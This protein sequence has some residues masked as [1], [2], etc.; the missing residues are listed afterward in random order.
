MALF[1]VAPM[2]LSDES[3]G[4]NGLANFKKLIGCSLLLASLFG[5]AQPIETAVA[6]TAASIKKTP[7]PK[8]EFKDFL[9]AY[10]ED[11]RVQQAFT[12]FPLRKQRLDLM[13]EPEPK[14]V[15]ESLR[16][17][18]VKYPIFP[19]TAER[20]SKSLNLRIDRLDASHVKVS[21]TKPDTDYQ[22]VY[23][24]SKAGCWRL[25]AIEDWSL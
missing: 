13:A 23:R 8:G 3:I 1:S 11:I 6:D 4:R 20:R 5:Q 22:V 18:R 7:C 14:P 10:S 19:T 15:L 25:N 17:D 21:L 16:A 12:H 24:F 9:R 2:C